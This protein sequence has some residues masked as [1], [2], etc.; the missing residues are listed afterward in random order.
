MEHEVHFQS[1]DKFIR[2]ATFFTLD[3]LGYK[4]DRA[5]NYM[6]EHL[7]REVKL[8]GLV[9]P[10][11]NWHSIGQIEVPVSAPYHDIQQ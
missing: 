9:A 5:L 6:A 10:A 3:S 2:T 8:R 7:V 4:H 1:S 11:D